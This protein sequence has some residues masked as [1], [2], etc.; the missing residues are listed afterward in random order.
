M[1]CPNCSTENAAGE[2][3][4]AACGTELVN[5]PSTL[6]S[7]DPQTGTVAP[8]DVAEPSLSAGLP[9]PKS[10]AL[11]FLSIGS[12]EFGLGDNS[13]LVI[14]REGST[15]CV[16]DIPINSENVS[17]TPVEVRAKNGIVTVH[18][19]GTSVGFRVIKYLQ[20]GEQIEVKV[21]DMLMFGPEEIVT[22]S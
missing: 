17:S 2:Q 14:A 11:V 10:N 19:M 22:I 3:F 18:D 16:P 12:K 1:T 7:A 21:G 4:C 9:A 20:P 6:V 5:E 13:V 8:A 15:K